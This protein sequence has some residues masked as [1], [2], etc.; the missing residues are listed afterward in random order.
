MQQSDS[1]SAVQVQSLSIQEE[2]QRL[3]RE[4]HDSVAQILYGIS[5]DA[6]AAGRA[7][8][9][10]NATRTE[11]RL[12]EIQA[13]ALQALREIRLLICELDPPLLKEGGKEAGEEVGLPAALAACLKKVEQRAGIQTEL[14]TSGVGRLPQAVENELYRIAVEALSNLVRHAHAQV[15]KVSLTQSKTRVCLDIQDDGRGFEAEAAQLHGGWGLRNMQARAEKIQGKFRLES[16][17]GAG[18]HISV[19]APLS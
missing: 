11:Q 7:C 13:E 8:R 3:G 2:R 19:E 9:A 15:V 14:H 4:L 12:A 1:P 16:Q 6:A 17:V 10:G 5:L 18:T